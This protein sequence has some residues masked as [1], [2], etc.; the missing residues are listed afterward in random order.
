[1]EFPICDFSGANRI[2]EPAMS[3]S[4]EKT[5]ATLKAATEARVN[6]AATAGDGLLSV[7]E[8]LTAL[9]LNTIRAALDDAAALSQAVFA[10]REPRV[11][12]ELQI[13]T[14]TPALQKSLAYARA[15]TGVSSQGQTE[16]LKLAEAGMSQWL[17]GVI[18]ALE[19]LNR[20]VPVGSG[21]AVQALKTAVVNASSAYEGATQLARQV[22]EATQAGVDQAAAVAV[23]AVSKGT[24]ATVGLLT[25][26]A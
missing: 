21:L 4:P 14:L 9:N 16:L 6:D 25:R 12:A 15:F 18:V 19:G 26:A 11:L 10:A 13:G 5:L 3:A 17:Q 2:K 1:M 22:S 23:D 20:S 24:A 7:V 8:H